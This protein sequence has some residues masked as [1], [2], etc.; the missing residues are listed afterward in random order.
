MINGDYEYDDEKYEKTVQ[1]L[2]EEVEDIMNSDCETDQDIFT[3]EQR[4]KD[5]KRRIEDTI[6]FLEVEDFLM[7]GAKGKEPN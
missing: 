3:K 4:I 5:V 1:K 6:V 7:D 2:E